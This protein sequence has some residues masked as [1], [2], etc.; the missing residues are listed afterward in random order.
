[1]I[2]G[3]WGPSRLPT[4]FLEGFNMDRRRFVGAGVVTALLGGFACAGG[5]GGESRQTGTVVQ[6]P[7]EDKESMEASAAAYRA[8][9][10]TQAKRSK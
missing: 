6:T 2:S 7:A 10:K 9:T 1:M 8:M 4:G 5:C 3:E